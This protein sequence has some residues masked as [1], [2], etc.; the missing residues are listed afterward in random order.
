MAIRAD[1]DEEQRHSTQAAV[2]T[3]PFSDWESIRPQWTELFSLNLAES[4]FMGP[5]WVEAWLQTFGALLKAEMVLVRDKGELVGAAVLAWPQ[6]AGLAKRALRGRRLCL[7]T[8]GEPR[9]ED[10]GV[11]YSGALA[12]PGYEDRVYDAL[13]TKVLGL[14]WDE[15]VLSGVTERTLNRVRARLPDCAE[16]TSWLPAF[17]VDLVPLR[18]AGK[19]YSSVLSSN[20]RG[21]LTRSMR[22]YAERG[23]V[24]L[25][26]AATADE[27]LEWL[28][29]M[30]VLHLARRLGKGDVTA[31]AS[32]RWMAFHD[33]LVRAAFP[34][35]GIRMLRGTAGGQVIGLLYN[36]VRDGA[37]YFYQSGFHF[38]AE[39]RLKPGYVTHALAIEGALDQGATS[40]DFLAGQEEAS[41]YKAQLSTERSV[42]AWT[43]FRRPSFGNSARKIARQMRNRVRR[44]RQGEAP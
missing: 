24:R 44:F 13:A 11:E 10:C 8:A 25:V 37:E 9:D 26:R 23:D 41:R 6:P 39:N 38:E 3:L 36:F 22:L 15:L 30:R 40:Y 35:G 33:R 29:E 7:H 14:G 27:A 5:A 31:F 18:A 17:R 28:H 1:I 43:T 19:P 21:Q 34:E 42:L 4:F 16:E 32:P 20:T 12:R 2:Q